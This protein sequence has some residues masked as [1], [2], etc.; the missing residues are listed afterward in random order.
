MELNSA[1]DKGYN[2][3][4]PKAESYEREVIDLQYLA[5]RSVDGLLISFYRNK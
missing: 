5:S 2:A 3:G 4:L 1:Y